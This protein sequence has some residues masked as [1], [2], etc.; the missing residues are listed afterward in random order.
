MIST[1]PPSSLFHSSLFHRGRSPTRQDRS[2]SSSSTQLPPI[3]NLLAVQNTSRQDLVQRPRGS[4]LPSYHSSGASPSG[5]NDSKEKRRRMGSLER[6]GRSDQ[7][8]ENGD[9]TVPIGGGVALPPIRVGNDS[10]PIRSSSFHG[11]PPIKT[12]LPSP[13]HLRTLDPLSP[14]SSQ[15]LPRPSPSWSSNVLTSGSSGDITGRFHPLSPPAVAVDNQPMHFQRSPSSPPTH[16][17]TGDQPPPASYRHRTSATSPATGGRLG[18]GNSSHSSSIS[19][20]PAFRQAI[21]KPNRSSLLSLTAPRQGRSI[22]SSSETPHHHH[23][24]SSQAA[25]LGTL[26]NA[27]PPLTLAGPSLSGNT[28]GSLPMSAPSGTSSFSR[29]N[30]HEGQSAGYEMTSHYLYTSSASSG[31]GLLDMSE[32]DG[33][34]RLKPGE[35][36]GGKKRRSRAT[37]EQL[38]LLNAVYQRT[39]F[40]TTVE[41]NELANRLGMTPRSVQI[42]FQ[43]KRQGAK[44]NETRRRELPPLAMTRPGSPQMPS[45]VPLTLAATSPPSPRYFEERSLSHGAV[46]TRRENLDSAGDLRGRA[47]RRRMSVNDLLR[48][49]ARDETRPAAGSPRY[50]GRQRPDEMDS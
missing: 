7:D 4:T 43:N 50:I 32:N 11:L 18:R 44:H 17:I 14:Q 23:S 15:S 19:P 16:V 5:Q 3:H 39:P 20:I 40:P 24:I 46:E 35:T 42:W 45:L 47:R 21:P 25:T 22:L 10:S 36:A 26:E 38:D 41:R 49:D 34:I 6:H 37:Q 31:P 9:T 33:V 30:S 8:D 1:G 48:Q 29:R 2:S 27:T 13:S 12:M 28:V